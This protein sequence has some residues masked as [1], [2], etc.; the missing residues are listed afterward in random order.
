MFRLRIS[1]ILSRRPSSKA[2]P[3]Q[4]KF[5]LN[6][7]LTSAICIWNNLGVSEAVL[8]V[9]SSSLTTRDLFPT[10]ATAQEQPTAELQRSDG[11]QGQDTSAVVKSEEPNVQNNIDNLWTWSI[12]GAKVAGSLAILTGSIKV[13]QVVLAYWRDEVLT[14]WDRVKRRWSIFWRGKDATD[15]RDRKRLR[16]IR[17]GSGNVTRTSYEPVE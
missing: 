1:E 6:L 5:L 12:N 11:N 7:L 9:P 16:K 15:A 10:A 8:V 13:I 2:V 17:K 3:M 14:W 4:S